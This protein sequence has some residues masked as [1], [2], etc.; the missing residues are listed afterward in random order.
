[1]ISSTD[2]GIHV[3]IVAHVQIVCKICTANTTI[4]KECSKHPSP[5]RRK[6]ELVQDC[7]LSLSGLW[8]GK[9]P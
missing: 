1:M 4:D 8:S 5:K 7:F 2:A 6:C 3:H 9:R